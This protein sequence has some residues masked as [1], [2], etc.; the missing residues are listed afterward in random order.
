VRRQLLGL[1]DRVE[2][3]EPDPQGPTD[4]LVVPAHA[5]G[6]TPDRQQRNGKHAVDPT[7]RSVP[8]APGG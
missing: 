6:Q 4:G 2:G 3:M 5:D 7:D 1:R 8:V